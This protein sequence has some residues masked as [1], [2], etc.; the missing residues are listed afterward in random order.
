MS[1]SG[2][3]A[4]AAFG[5]LVSVASC[6]TPSSRATQGAAPSATAEQVAWEAIAKGAVIVDVRT[7]EEFQQGHL[8]G[9]IHIPYDQ[10]GTRAGEIP[11]GQQQPMV[12]YCRSG[13]RSGIAKQTL[14]GLGYS[15]TING[16]G[17]EALERTKPQ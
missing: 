11:G 12:L 4:L 3:L 8:P 15:N 14:D 16:G 10:L 5:L 1:R 2:W 9:A 13:R 6:V 7:D 17:Y